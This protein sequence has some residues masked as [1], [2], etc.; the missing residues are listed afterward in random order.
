MAPRTLYVPW[1]V[2]YY[3]DKALVLACAESPWTEVLFCRCTALAKAAM[4]DGLIT[5]ADLILSRVPNA[6]KWA[7][8]LVRVGLWLETDEGWLI[9]SYAKHNLT[10]EQVEAK[11]AA[12]A[13]RVAKYRARNTPS[14]DAC[15]ALQ[16][17]LPAEDGNAL[18]DA[19]PLKG[20]GLRVKGEDVNPKPRTPDGAV[21]VAK[22]TKA[23]KAERP[24]D[25]LFDAL[26]I[27]AEGVPRDRFG[28][29]TKRQSSAIGVAT[30]EIRNAG[31][32][33]TTVRSACDAYRRQFP[34]ASLTASAIAKH[35]ARLQPGSTAGV[36]SQG[37][38]PPPRPV[39]VSDDDTD[40]LVAS[41][42]AR[43]RQTAVAR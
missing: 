16:G 34:G 26:T 2:D 42:I 24:R 32:D 25:L 11:R 43:A 39:V 8:V 30:A 13:E 20:E 29:L 41:E 15:N 40:E 18:R 9:R 3:D 1:V 28:T 12:D 5:P 6:N 19:L 14:N 22:A 10:A 4:S 7:K 33:H 21:A 36:G 35:W 37:S 31:G 23:E 38:A 17:V 27:L